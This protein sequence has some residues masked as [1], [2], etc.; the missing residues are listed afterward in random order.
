MR[1]YPQMS[2]PARSTMST[3][4]WGGYNHNLRISEGESYDEKNLSSDEFPILAPRKARGVYAKPAA[5]QGLIE[6]DSLCWVDGS[7]FVLNG[8]QIEMNLS[9]READCP[10]KLIGMG[11]YVV[12]LPDKKYINTQDETDWGNIEADWQGE[13]VHLAL[14]RG[15]G[16]QIEGAAESVT[17]PVAPLDGQYWV[18]TG[19]S[20]NRL[21][22]YS[23][24]DAMWSEVGTT[25]VKLTAAGIDQ[26]FQEGDGVQISG[27]EETVPE[28]MGSHVIHAKG[29]GYLV[30]VGMLPREADTALRIERR[31]PNLD[32]V[33]ESGN[34]LWGCRYGAA[35]NGEIVNEIYASKLGDF[36]NWSC[37]EGVSTD[38]W[39]GSCG[40]DGQWTGAANYLGYPVFFKQDHIHR[41]YGSMPSQYSIRDTAARG[42][43]LGC[44]DSLAMVE[45]CLIYKSRSGVCLY[46]GSMPKEIGQA[47]GQERYGQ[48]IA[49]GLGSKY[50]LS[51]VSETTGEAVL[52]TY[53]LSRGVWHKED[54]LRARAFARARNDIYCI[55]DA[56]GFVLCLTGHGEPLEEKV[57]WEYISGELGL[58][59]TSGYATV[60]MPEEK[61]IAKLQLRLNMEPGSVFR[62]AI[63]YDG[64]GVWQDVASLRGGNLR[65]FT[66]PIR[67]RRCDWLRLKLTGR[68][69]V[70]VYSLIKTMEGVSDTHSHEGEMLDF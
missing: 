22:L 21:M 12:I 46:D 5:C 9:I 69:M 51:M 36:K 25:Y 63:E 20:P 58:R 6:K 29:D 60:G 66:L 62:V 30:I 55:D 65:S 56:T 68:G 34:R 33:I 26:A 45:E 3:E 67:P 54:S 13:A 57:E 52:F 10:K 49:G 32:H 38:S 35:R 28:L 50:Y 16:E 14:C 11:S 41:V 39:V 59:T 70:R 27:A 23:E 53:D 1:T 19:S 37:F 8:H 64:S 47:L 15:D 31:M 61:Y 7:K 24:A 43:Q 18:D 2:Q 42:V 40:S 48:A 4:S 44:G 17:A